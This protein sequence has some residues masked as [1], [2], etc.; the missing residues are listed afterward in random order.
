[1]G[2]AGATCLRC[3][4]STVRTW[5]ASTETHSRV[6]PATA[7]NSP[8]VLLWIRAERCRL[9]TNLSRFVAGRIFSP[10]PSPQ[11]YGVHSE[12]PLVDHS[13]SGRSPVHNHR[14]C[15]R[16]PLSTHCTACSIATAT[17]RLIRHD[18]L[19]S[20]STVASACCTPG[21][22][23]E[24]NPEKAQ[25]RRHPAPQSPPHPPPRLRCLTV[26]DDQTIA[27]DD[28]H[29]GVPAVWQCQQYFLRRMPKVRGRE[30]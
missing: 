11:S 28:N 20:P 15:R 7:E 18:A 22:V 9:T 5:T 10:D 4:A 2:C 29:A 8:S 14:H 30:D 25:N 21:I 23:N 12:L 1:M 17:W 16:L 27:H 19:C 26:V 13:P 6:S 24:W 3:S